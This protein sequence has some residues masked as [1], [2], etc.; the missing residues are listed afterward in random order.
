MIS[1]LPGLDH[2]PRKIVLLH[3]LQLQPGGI[4]RPGCMAPGPLFFKMLSPDVAG[5]LDLSEPRLPGQHAMAVANM[6]PVCDD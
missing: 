2:L 4:S 3:L 6:G 5:A 1:Q